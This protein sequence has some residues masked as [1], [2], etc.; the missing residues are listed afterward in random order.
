MGGGT[1]C[2][3]SLG[4]ETN[5]KSLVAKLKPKRF[6][7]LAVFL[8]GS[9]ATLFYREM[10]QL[11]FHPKTIG[12]DFFDSVKVVNDARGTMNGAIFGAPF[13]DDAFVSRY[14]K[15]YGNDAQVSWAAN[16]Y[17]FAILCA[18]LLGNE[19]SKLSPEVIVARFRAADQ[20]Q[21]R[22][23]NYKYNESSEGSDIDFRVVMRE[24]K[25]NRIVSVSEF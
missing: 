3:W 8:V 20:T 21:G 19:T 6:D 13:V 25:E 16:A 14:V 18:R 4:D 5:F 11:N 2:R 22:A 9:Q 7:V 17:E 1:W 15:Q 24:V 10:N 12:T 23:A